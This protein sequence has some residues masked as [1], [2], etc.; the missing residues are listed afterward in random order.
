M[1]QSAEARD[2]VAASNTTANM[3]K[4]VAQVLAVTGVVAGGAIMQLPGA[5]EWGK[6]VLISGIVGTLCAF[7]APAFVALMRTIFGT[8]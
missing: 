2:L 3:V 8:I 6:R 1:T 7:G 5:G 4:N